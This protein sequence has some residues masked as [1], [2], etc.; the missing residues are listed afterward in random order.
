VTEPFVLRRLVLLGLPLL[1]FLGGVLWLVHSRDSRRDLA[2]AAQRGAD[3][4]RTDVRLIERELEAS[5]A[6]LIYM[7]GSDIA[8]RALGDGPDAFLARTTL[9]DD[10]RRLAASHGS[11]SRIVLLSLSGTTVVDSAPAAPPFVRS[12]EGRPDEF[13]SAGGIAVSQVVAGKAPDELVIRFRSTVVDPN[14]ARIGEL[15]LEY[16]ASQVAQRIQRAPGLLS[17]SCFLVDVEGRYLLDPNERGRGQADGYQEPAFVGDHPDAWSRMQGV[18]RG[19]FLDA[20]GQTTFQ[21][22]PSRPELGPPIVSNDLRLVLVHH[23]PRSR[24]FE[25]SLRTRRRVALVL[26]LIAVLSIGLIWRMSYADLLRR[27]GSEQ[28]AVSAGRLRELARRLLQVQEE[29]RRAVA[30]DLHDDLGQIATAVDIDLK[31]AHR[32]SDEEKRVQLLGRA[33]EGMG[34]LIETLRGVLGRLRATAIEDLGLEGALRGL[35][36]EVEQAYGVVVEAHIE[37]DSE[38]PLEVALAGFRVVQEALSNVAHHAGVDRAEVKVRGTSNEL[39]VQV[40]DRGRG[41]DSAKDPAGRYG[42]LGMRE[43]VELLAGD[44][45]V[46]SSP[47][48]G[49]RVRA[50]IAVRSEEESS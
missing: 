29:E 32:A 48:G 20:E 49:T 14:R 28:L 17:G 25:E 1:A 37:V 30:R 34:R 10:Y 21:W 3:V 18:P 35:F 47:G 45:R 23:V 8:R 42:L 12:I 24:V 9:G 46:E 36:R 7:R 6:T 13:L 44:V 15:V 16:S 5:T 39:E 33:T 2:Q 26:G 22:I 4:V 41:F 31:R 40:A 50:R 27:R 19:Q 43:R 38:P 11:V